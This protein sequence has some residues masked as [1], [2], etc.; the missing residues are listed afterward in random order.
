MSGLQVEIAGN[1]LKADLAKP[2]DISIP[3]RFDREQFRAFGATPARS[4]AYLAGDTP[5]QVSQ[6]AGCNCP[7]FHFSAHLHGTHT[8]CLGHITARDYVLQDV[9]PLELLTTALLIS[10]NPILGQDCEEAYRPQMESKDLVLT[11]QSLE[12][13]VSQAQA[14]L[15]LQAL[16]VRTLPNDESKKTR[17]YDLEPAPYFSNEAMV[18]IGRLGVNLLLVD[19]P[20]VDRLE[21]EGALS[22]HHLF[23]DVPLGRH[24]RTSPSQKSITEFIWVPES[25]KDGEYLLHLNVANIRSDAAPSRPVLYEIS[26]YD[27]L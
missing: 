24:D 18:Y 22:N 14:K 3:V 13:A 20:S 15:P 9:L 6:G 23:W 7:V 25:V 11:R 12:Q 8:E 10:L 19:T 27:Q 2:I 21:D 5:L 1:V 17:N 4:E 16:I 26:N